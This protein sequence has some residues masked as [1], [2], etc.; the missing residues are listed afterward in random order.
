[1]NVGTRGERVARRAHLGRITRGEGGQATAEL[2]LVFPM[3]VVLVL[4]IV[5]LGFVARDF[6]RVAHASRAAARAASVDPSGD[7]ARD[8]VRHL[9]GDASVDIESADEIGDPVTASV[10]FVSRTEVPIIGVLLPDVT[11][12]DSTTMAAEQK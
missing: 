2:A 9:L 11:I 12:E 1:M 6:V 5:Q 3:L 10:G 4:L 8:V 7:R